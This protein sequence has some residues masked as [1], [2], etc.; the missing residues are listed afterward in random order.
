MFNF[1]LIN[2]PKGLGSYAQ[3]YTATCYLKKEKEKRER[4]RERKRI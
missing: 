2:L 4:E 1:L 3:N